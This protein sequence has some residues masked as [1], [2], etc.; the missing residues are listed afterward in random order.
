MIYFLVFVA[1]VTAAPADW[2][3]SWKIDVGYNV[4]YTTASLCDVGG[5]KL[6]GVISNAFMIFGDV[7]GNTF[8]GRFCDARRNFKGPVYDLSALNASTD[9]NT[10]TNRWKNPQM[11]GFQGPIEGNITLT[12][13]GESI[14]GSYTYFG[15]TQVRIVT[16]TMV[17]KK[18][19]DATSCLSFELTN[20][21]ISATIYTEFPGAADANSAGKVLFNDPSVK[22][23][24]GYDVFFRG[25]QAS[26]QGGY[27]GVCGGWFVLGVNTAFIAECSWRRCYNDL[28]TEPDPTKNYPFLDPARSEVFFGLIAGILKTPTGNYYWNNANYLA[29]YEYIGAPAETTSEAI[30][31]LFFDVV[32]PCNCGDKCSKP[33]FSAIE[34]P[35]TLASHM[36]KFDDQLAG[37]VY[38]PISSTLPPP[39]PPHSGGISG[40]FSSLF[41]IF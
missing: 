29:S 17:Q 5:G 16:G 9:Y 14:S 38:T 22:A 3:G 32:D 8:S 35:T 6:Q 4:N 24:M 34:C 26:S 12:L 30:T 39:P 23:R 37:Y 2:A 33:S 31:T 10:V 1:A 7:N 21:T 20:H 13:N 18:T 19:L 40:G 36:S 27:T 15:E 28:C 11:F 41:F 25:M